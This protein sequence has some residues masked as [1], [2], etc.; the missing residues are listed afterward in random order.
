[1]IQKG[2]YIAEHI[3]PQEGE[4]DDEQLQPNGVDLRID[5]IYEITNTAILKD[6]EYDKGVREESEILLKDNFSSLDKNSYMVMKNKPHIV[7]YDEIIK[8]PE[9]HIG[10][11][12]PRSRL[13]RSGGFLT[14]A[15][16]DQGYEGRGEG[17]LIPLNNLVIENDMRIVQFTLFEALRGEQLY[18]GDHQ[19]ERL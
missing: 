4:L 17:L 7:V 16:W 12:F 8:I 3:T 15:M 19:K 18:D 11:V 13:M 9:G 6:K 1:M 14:T 5:K 10:Y 2:E